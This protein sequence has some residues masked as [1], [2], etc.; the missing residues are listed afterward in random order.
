MAVTQRPMDRKI[1]DI[2]FRD[3]RTNTWKREKARVVDVVE[4]VASLKWG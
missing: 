3:R 4:R 2:S 1:L